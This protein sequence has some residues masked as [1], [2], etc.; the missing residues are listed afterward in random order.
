MGAS[1]DELDSSDEASSP[2]SCGEQRRLAALA[3]LRSLGLK[4]TG[5][6]IHTIST[7]INANG[8]GAIEFHELVELMLSDISIEV[9][10][11]HEHLMKVFKAFDRDGNRFI[12]AVEPETASFEDDNIE[13]A[14]TTAKASTASGVG[15][16]F[17][18]GSGLDVEQRGRGL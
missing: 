3:P 13:R 1:F 9:I 17:N 4:P 8:N 2:R 14:S 16:G 7:S 18:D 10:P 15:R 11:N 12:S 5:N 6:Q